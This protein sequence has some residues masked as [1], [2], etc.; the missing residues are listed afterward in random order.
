M[1]PE[2][3]PTK[4]PDFGKASGSVGLSQAI[5]TAIPFLPA[6]GISGNQEGNGRAA[7]GAS[8]F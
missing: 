7:I 2:R 6:I 8:F 3:N 4:S 1:I 5:G